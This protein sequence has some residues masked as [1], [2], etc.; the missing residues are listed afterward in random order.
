MCVYCRVSCSCTLS[1]H[2]ICVHYVFC[3]LSTW[4]NWLIDRKSEAHAAVP[5]SASF[6][7]RSRIALETL[8]LDEVEY[9]L[10]LNSSKT[11]VMWCAT[12]RRQHLL[13]ACGLLVDGLMV[14]PVSHVRDLGIDADLSMRT[15]AQE[16]LFWAD[17]VDSAKRIR[18]LS[19]LLTGSPRPLG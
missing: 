8:Q 12:S 3:T 18:S 17:S 9:M 10:P 7:R 6:R 13:P 4:T 16:L 19:V 14:D 11:E 1:L 5:P 15:H 2:T